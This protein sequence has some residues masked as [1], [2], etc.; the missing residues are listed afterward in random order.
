MSNFR[1]GSL[2]ILSGTIYLYIIY[3]FSFDYLV[4]LYIY[5]DFETS[6]EECLNILII[7]TP[8]I[9]IISS[10]L[11]IIIQYIIS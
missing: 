8:H 10:N 4:Y 2:V 1:I 11:F 3:S 6:I 7:D 5:C 9:S